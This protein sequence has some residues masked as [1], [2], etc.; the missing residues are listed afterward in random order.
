VSSDLDRRF[1]ALA[2]ALARRGLGNVAPNPA[3]GCVIVQGS[4]IVGRGWTQ[5]GGRPHAETQALAQAGAAARGAT[6]YVTL[7]PCAHQGA[8]PPCAVALAQAGIVRVVSATTDPDP[9][10][11]GRGHALLRRAGVEVLEKLLEAEARA[12]N[13]G[14]LLHVTEGRPWLTLKLAVT[15]DGRIATAD[16]ASRWITGPEARRAV[17]LMRGQHDAVMVGIGTALADDPNLTARDLGLAWQPIRII[18]DSQARLSADSALARTAAEVPVWICHSAPAQPM[19]GLRL[20]RCAATT[21]G[22]VDLADALQRLGAAGL[23]RIF[24]EGGA[25]LAAGLLSTGLADEVVCISAGRFFGA[26]GTPSVAEIGDV[27]LPSAPDFHLV[28]HRR[29][30][31]DVLHR[32]LHAK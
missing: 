2:L 28:E 16:G 1:M 31:D 7:E 18:V 8:T 15:L 4:I 13:A 19:P 12:L 14:F 32:W 30:G 20:I 6:A 24:C 17:H 3:V 23:T 29:L 10:V 26:G 9:R 27:V 25:G 11:S 5:P 21:A 22:Q